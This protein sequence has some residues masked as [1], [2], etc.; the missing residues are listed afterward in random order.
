MILLVSVFFIIIPVTTGS[1]EKIIL[2]ETE[3]AEASELEEVEIQ[4]MTFDDY[5]DDIFGEKAD[6]A[7]A[8]LKHES[9]LNLKAKHYNC[10][11][12]NEKTGKLYSTSCKKE[13]IKKAWSVDCSIAQINVKGTVC[14]SY[15][16][17]LEGSMK[18]TEEIYKNQG[19]NAW[20]SYKSGAYLKFLNV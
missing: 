11:Y 19:L 8:V 10:R 18:A 17:T 16:M 20:V 15:L 9:S 7:T 4:I 13:D 14:P 3:K 5:M 2:N 6:I 1:I 12:I